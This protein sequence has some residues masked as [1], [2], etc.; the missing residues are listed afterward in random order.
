MASK[1]LSKTFE[2]V[3]SDDPSLETSVPTD[4]TMSPDYSERE[5]G[6]NKKRHIT[7]QLIERKQLAHDMQLLKIELSQKNMTIESLKV[8]HL[9]RV[10]E[11]EEKLHD[12]THQK[13]ILQARL[14]SELQIQQDEAKKRQ[15]MISKELELVRTKQQHLEAANERLRE[16][17]GDVRKSLRDLSLSEEKY[18]QLKALPDEEL[19]LRDYVAVSIQVHLFVWLDFTS[20]LSSV[21][22]GVFV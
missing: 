9:Q 4:L 11:L 16:K 3:E 7:K 6:R 1:D 20:W 21:P 13:Q 18:Y 10:E 12:V 14:E 15:L 19:S 8:E 22:F 2:D 5:G 17:A